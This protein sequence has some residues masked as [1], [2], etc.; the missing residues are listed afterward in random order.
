[1]A[2]WT[3]LSTKTTRSSAKLTS[4]GICILRVQSG[5]LR[6]LCESSFRSL[7]LVFMKSGHVTVLFL[8][9]VVY[10]PGKNG[11]I[12]LTENQPFYSI[13]L[14]KVV[15]NYNFATDDKELELNMTGD[16]PFSEES[17]PY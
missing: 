9:R 17:D 6:A 16:C 14:F 5:W 10:F 12:T 4:S 13:K 3:R 11:K 7:F 8:S 2:K 1:M 15:L